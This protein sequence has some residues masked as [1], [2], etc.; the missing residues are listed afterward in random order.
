MY[1]YLYVD[2]PP[3]FTPLQDLDALLALLKSC[4]RPKLP[5]AAVLRP[6]IYKRLSEQPFLPVNDKLRVIPAG[7]SVL[8]DP[9]T[10]NPA[11][12]QT[13][14]CMMFYSQEAL[15]LYL[16]RGKEPLAWVRYCCE[17]AG[18]P[19]PLEDEPLLPQIE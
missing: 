6:D 10:D 4:N 8:P 9:V 13:E 11:M 18:I 14:E 19:Y 16:Q 17:Q 15:N 3:M 1:L 12:V 7:L 5:I 2:T